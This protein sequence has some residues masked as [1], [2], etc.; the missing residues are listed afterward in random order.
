MHELKVRLPPEVT[1]EEARLL[2]A[3]KLFERGRLSLGQAAHMA[4]Y[5][6][7]TFMELLGTL[8]VPVFDYP[9]EDLKDEVDG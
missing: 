3:A 8:G 2:P 7:A 9:P 1:E 6:R 4:G 5:A